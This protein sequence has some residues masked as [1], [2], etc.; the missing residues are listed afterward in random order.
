[1]S[2]QIQPGTRARVVIDGICGA[3]GSWTTIRSAETGCEWDFDRDEPAV[4]VTP[5]DPEQPTLEQVLQ[6]HAWDRYDGDCDCG[7]VHYN[8]HRHAAHLAEQLRAAGVAL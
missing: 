4:T 1:M 8:W 6:T 3:F 5:L 7:E 2:E